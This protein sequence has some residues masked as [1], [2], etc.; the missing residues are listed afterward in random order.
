MAY[1]FVVFKLLALFPHIRNDY[2][3]SID[4]SNILID[5][6]YDEIV[7]GIDYINS[8]NVMHNK[9]KRLSSI[10]ALGFAMCH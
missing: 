7:K 1:Y 8:P 4:A 6:C 5:D 3:T 9:T 10:E 2:R